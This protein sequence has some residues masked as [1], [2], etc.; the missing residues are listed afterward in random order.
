VRLNWATASE[1]GNAG[2]YVQRRRIGPQGPQDRWHRLGFVEGAG[3]TSDPRTYRFVDDDLPF[4]AD[5][6]TYRLR[7]VDLDGAEHY[8]DPRTVERAAPDR[9]ALR[10]PF[11]NPATQRVTFHFAV[12]EPTDVR[13]RVYDVMGRR[14]ATWRDGRVQAGRHKQTGRVRSLA[15]GLYFVRLVAGDE[16][17][18]R[19]LTV[20]R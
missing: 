1:T 7:Q 15:S 6:L 14:V 4:E 2:F 13:V 8:S 5:S 9:V 12:P 17:R 20:V 11:P 3:T 18:T 10:K 19:R 16:R